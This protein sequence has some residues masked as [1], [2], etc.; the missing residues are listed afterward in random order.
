MKRHPALVPFSREHRHL[1]FMCQQMKKNAPV[2]EN[3]PVDLPGKI[4]YVSGQLSRL[5]L[6]HLEKEEKALFRSLHGFDVET[7]TLLDELMNE[8]ILIREIFNRLV[9]MPSI[10]LMDE[11]GKMLERHI[12]KE[13]RILFEL[14]AARIP[15]S[16]LMDPEL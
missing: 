14:I 16:L 9:A 10:E 6:P 13:E 3:Y 2:Y 5:L 8:H 4:R 15:E 7:D 12:R 11:A 1:L